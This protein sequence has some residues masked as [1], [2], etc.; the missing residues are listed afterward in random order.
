MRR[1]IASCTALLIALCVPAYSSGQT[2]TAAPAASPIEIQISGP[3]VI[4]VGQDLHFKVTLINHSAVPMALTFWHDG[5]A[6]SNFEWSITDTA[7]RWL[8]PPTPIGPQPMVCLLSG[9]VSEE[10]IQVLVPGEK[11]VYTTKADPSNDFAFPG[12]GFYKV[13]LRFRF[14]PA[15]LSPLDAVEREYKF[16][17][18]GKP[19]PKRAM[20]YKTPKIDVSSN[21]WTMYLT[22]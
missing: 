16:L 12:K 21:V 3:K 1:L 10:Q 5:W 20:L 8:P 9:A 2:Q 19:G 15:T 6:D 7:D 4:R 11:F 17:A 13:R 22:R 14:D 18:R